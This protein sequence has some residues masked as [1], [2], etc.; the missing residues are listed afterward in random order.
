M[1]LPA[2]NAG[3]GQALRRK[4]DLRLLTGQGRYSDDVAMPGQAYAAMVR[5]PHA[6]A[7]IRAIDTAQARAVPGVIAV[8]TGHDALADG[9]QPI[10]HRPTPG[11]PPDILLHNRDGSPHPLAPH[12]ALAADRARFVGEA[13]AMVVA[14]TVHA[15]KQAAELVEVEYEVLPCV[16]VAR[17]ALDGAVAPLHDGF[18]NLCIDADVG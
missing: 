10:P 7:R 11:S 5:S 3:I 6:H 15:A 18:A 1:S 4:E 14:E 16:T 8:L 13:V 17:A 12:R 9:L 2:M